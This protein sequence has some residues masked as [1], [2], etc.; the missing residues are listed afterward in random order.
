M[1]RVSDR[2]PAKAQTLVAENRES[3]VDSDENH[4]AQEKEKDEAAIKNNDES[5]EET[6][7]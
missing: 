1:S 7:E 6:V 2:R 5:V 4:N 3:V